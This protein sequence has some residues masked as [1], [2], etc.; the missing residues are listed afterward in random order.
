MGQ[1]IARVGDAVFAPADGHP[2]G[3]PVPVTG[4]ITSGALED[5]TN[6]RATATADP[7]HK[8]THA[9]CAGP[10]NFY[11]SQGSPVLYIEDYPAGRS[12][13][14]TQHCGGVGSILSLCS[15]DTYG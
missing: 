11:V 2:F 15:L 12:G 10:N 3:F 5:F 13:D 14:Q 7:S 4:I 1:P 8:S 9:A 6:D